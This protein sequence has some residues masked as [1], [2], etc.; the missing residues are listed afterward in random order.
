MA[1]ACTDQDR[2][3]EGIPYFDEA[4]R[5][6]PEHAEAHKGKAMAMLKLGRLPGKA[7]P[8][9]SGAWRCKDLIALRSPRPLWDGSPLEG[10]TILL[11]SEQGIG[12]TIQFVRY[13]ARQVAKVGPSSWP[14]PLR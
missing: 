1:V 13:C 9:M 14:A 5:L 8:S 6:D 3:D 12:D 4:I 2:L 7:G 10:K 11:H